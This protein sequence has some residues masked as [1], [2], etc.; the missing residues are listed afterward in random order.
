MAAVIGIKIRGFYLSYFLFWVIFFVPALLHYDIPRKLLNKALPLLEQLDHSM[1]YERRSILDK[2][3][4]LVN[5][6]IPPNDEIDRQE[7]EYLEMFKLNESKKK[8]REFDNKSGD[9]EE[10]DESIEN[11]EEYEEEELEEEEEEE[12]EQRQQQQ[13]SENENDDSSASYDDRFKRPNKSKPKAKSSKNKMP[14]HLYEDDDDELN[15]LLPDEPFPSIHEVVD[16]ILKSNN[17]T[18]EKSTQQTQNA[19][20]NV[21]DEVDEEFLFKDENFLK[22][23]S[24]GDKA[25]RKRVKNRPSLLDYYENRD[26]KYVDLNTKSTTSVGE[27]DAAAARTNNNWKYA[28]PSLSLYASSN[29]NQNLIP[30]NRRNFYT[31]NNENIDETFDFLDE[32]LNKYNNEAK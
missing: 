25:M 3:D 23:I 11:E 4:L 1:K 28:S 30:L 12:E 20:A 13:Q 8:R 27:T 9:E 2:R 14:S 21:N 24:S 31:E 17:N 15:S 6:T 26:T 32:E 16:D 7:N 29:V 18:I 5:V 10:E 22:N 19:T